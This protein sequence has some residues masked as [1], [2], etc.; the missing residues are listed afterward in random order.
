MICYVFVLVLLFFLLIR[1]YKGLLN[2]P[3]IVFAIFVLN[4]IGLLLYNGNA[5]FYCL[6]ILAF[7]VGIYISEFFFKGY[8]NKIFA[9]K[10]YFSRKKELQVTFALLLLF[11]FLG[12]LYYSKG[13]PVFSVNPDRVRFEQQNIPFFGFLYRINYWTLPYLVL[14]FL[15]LCERRKKNVFCKIVFVFFLLLT[16]FLNVLT[17]SKGAIIHYAL[18]FLLYFSYMNKIKKGVH[19]VYLGVFCILSFFVILKMFQINSGVNSFKEAFFIFLYRITLGSAEGIHLIMT[20]FTE[21]FGYGFG[22]FSFIKPIYTFLGTLRIIEKGPLTM[23]TGNFIGIYYRGYDNLAPFTYT[24]LAQGYLD[25]GKMGLVMYGFIFGF[26]LHQNYIRIIR[27]KDNFRFVQFVTYDWLL[28]ALASWGYIDGWITFAFIYII[29]PMCLI[30]IFMIVLPSKISFKVL[31]KE[32]FA[33][34][35]KNRL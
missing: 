30:R 6:G 14:V 12:L 26:I 15:F 10:S 5:F 16:F 24:I 35:N 23:D 28:I 1:I 3:I 7:V 18:L 2:A 27:N 25:F 31:T 22:W 8:K 34:E 9:K 33:Y 13:I 29:F 20:D 19:Y 32:R 4:F 11:S 21:I 17:G